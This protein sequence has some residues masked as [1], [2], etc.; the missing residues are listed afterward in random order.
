MNTHN[1]STPS[2]AQPNGAQPN[3]AQ[4]NG[5]QPNGAHCND[6]ARPEEL[7][8]A[9]PPASDGTS[10]ALAAEPV[11]AG[12]AKVN[13]GDVGDKTIA[14]SDSDTSPNEKVEP[15][16]TVM[17]PVKDWNT[18]SLT[19]ATFDLFGIA[20]IYK[21]GLVYPVS[22][23]E[24]KTVQRRVYPDPQ[25]QPA[26]RWADSKLC[27][28]NAPRFY[29]IKAIKSCA[30]EQGRLFV[31][32]QESDVWIMGQ[33]GQK[34]VCCIGKSDYPQLAAILVAQKVGSITAIF[35]NTLEGRRE[36]LAMYD[37]MRGS[38]NLNPLI[39]PG[40][41][42][43]SSEEWSNL[44]PEEFA[45]AIGQLPSLHPV[46]FENW[47]NNPETMS[48]DLPEVG[49][50]NDGPLLSYD[51]KE[52]EHLP[53]P[54]CLIEDV[55]RSEGVTLLTGMHSSGKSF[56]AVDMALSVSQGQTWQGK[57]TQSGSAFYFSAEG[58]EGFL[59]RIHAWEQT[60]GVE[61]VP[62]FFMV[63]DAVYLVDPTVQRRVIETVRARLRKMKLAPD[64]AALLI[65]DT[66]TRYRGTL[67][68]NSS[69]DMGQFMNAAAEV[70]REL[71]AAVLVVHHNNREGGHR[72]SSALPN[73]AYG[74]LNI[75]NPPNKKEEGQLIKIQVVKLKDYS[76]RHNITLATRVVELD[77]VDN[78]G[79]P[80]SSLA[81]ALHEGTESEK[82][83]LSPGEKK[84]LQ[85]LMELGDAGATSTVWKKAAAKDVPSTSFDRARVRLL[86]LGAVKCDNPGVAGAI[87]SVVENWSD[88]PTENDAENESD[89]EDDENEAPL[90]PYHYQLQEG[91]PEVDE[92]NPVGSWLVRYR[93]EGQTESR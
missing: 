5:A 6:A 30:H 35:E 38:V 36:A 66:L 74:H 60:H 73:D 86:A 72:G 81:L 83:R 62:N 90:V 80:F 7:P 51:E 89:V 42:G 9:I 31:V 40:L 21:V 53:R 92:W 18:L 45:G 34:A 46:I 65:F 29:N 85:A 64:G 10:A 49:A 33:N 26:I 37:A 82:E 27:Q 24:G 43:L 79:K 77:G 52:M 78:F 20:N 39:L 76:Q 47:R 91:D 25:K 71:G 75:S 48:E 69:T 93:R 44:N 15:N 88:S 12:I 84:A 61:A 16:I 57:Q 23:L 22:D 54:Q 87:Y 14:E 59:G 55:V 63:K 1:S 32:P 28:S 13:D 17:Q 58:T 50:D 8:L 67:D 11:I 68:E 56:V 2:G 19:K 70:G 41:S 3:G 4:P